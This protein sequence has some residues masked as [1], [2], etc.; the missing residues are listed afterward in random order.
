MT[1]HK[2]SARFSTR[3]VASIVADD[4]CDDEDLDS[5]C[6]GLMGVEEGGRSDVFQLYDISVHIYLSDSCQITPSI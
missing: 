3:E 1:E 5:I 2:D 4:F 6:K